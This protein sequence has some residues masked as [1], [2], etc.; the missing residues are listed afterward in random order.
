MCCNGLRHLMSEAILASMTDDQAAAK[1]L[2]EAFRAAGIDQQ[3]AL[4]AVAHEASG[5]HEHGP[6]VRRSGRLARGTTPRRD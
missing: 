2:A 1:A 4:K 6:H 3:P 5:S